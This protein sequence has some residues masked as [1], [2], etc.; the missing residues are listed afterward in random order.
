[1]RRDTE[2]RTDTV[3]R[4]AFPAASYA[5]TTN[6]DWPAG[7]V[8]TV[9]KATAEPR[10]IGSSFSADESNRYVIRVTAT[11]STAVPVSE[12]LGER[13]HEALRGATNRKSGATA[14]R[15]GGATGSAAGPQAARI[16]AIAP[17]A[18]P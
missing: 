6:A 11:L 8:I 10:T 4:V 18:R 16:N 3:A 7:G 9:S 12:T 14:S 1:M 15:V 2:Y 13:V 5:V 17:T